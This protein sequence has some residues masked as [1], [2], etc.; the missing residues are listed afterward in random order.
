MA[1]PGLDRCVRGKHRDVD[2][3]DHVPHIT[4]GVSAV[5]EG[6][7]DPGHPHD[8]RP[9]PEVETVA[10][11]QDPQG[12]GELLPVSPMLAVLLQ[13]QG[14]LDHLDHL[15]MKHCPLFSIV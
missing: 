2:V 8:P 9:Q 11:R 3:G 15:N 1:Q 6:Q 7:S 4:G 5:H 13:S 10:V 12:P 14:L